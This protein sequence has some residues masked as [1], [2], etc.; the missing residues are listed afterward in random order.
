VKNE[1][2]LQQVDEGSVLHTIKIRKVNRIVHSLHRKCFLKHSVEG[3]L[4]TRIEVTGRRG[5]RL[6]QVLDDL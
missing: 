2:I 1:E 3:K 4:G 5:R 6:K